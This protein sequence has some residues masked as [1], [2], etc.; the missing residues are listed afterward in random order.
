EVKG[1]E[2]AGVKD[3]LG[4]EGEQAWVRPS[5]ALVK[6]WRLAQ[7][8]RSWLERGALVSSESP[9][10]MSA[11]RKEDTKPA[12]L[13]VD[14]AV[15]LLSL[16]PFALPAG[17][18]PIDGVPSLP[19]PPDLHEGKGCNTGQGGLFAPLGLGLPADPEVKTWGKGPDRG[20]VM[21]MVLHFLLWED[22][23]PVPAAVGLAGAR[24]VGINLGVEEKAKGDPITLSELMDARGAR[25]RARGEGLLLAERLLE[26]LKSVPATTELL[27]AVT[28]NLHHACAGPE[29][30]AERP[31]AVRVGGEQ[32]GLGAGSEVGAR[33]GAGEE[34]TTLVSGQG[35]QPQG[36][37]QADS[38]KGFDVW[39]RSKIH[40]LSGV[41]SCN[42]RIKSELVAAAAQFL[43]RCSKLLQWEASLL[44]AVLDAV[45]LDYGPE[46]HG[47]LLQ[48]R[49][50]PEVIALVDD[51]DL[52]VACVAMG[53][54]DA[55]LRCIS[56][57]ESDR[58]RG[59]DGQAT[60]GSPEDLGSPFQT[61]FLGAVR[62]RLEDVVEEGVSGKTVIHEVGGVGR[63][64][65]AQAGDVEGKETVPALEGG[66]HPP[67]PPAGGRLLLEGLLALSPDSPGMVV[68]HFPL[69]V[70][71]TLSLWL[72][73]PAELG[74]TGLAG[75]AQSNIDSATGD[76]LGEDVE[77]TSHSSG[78][79]LGVRSESGL[80]LRNTPMLSLR[81]VDA[82]GLGKAAT[83]VAPEVERRSHRL[84][85]SGR[86]LSLVRPVE[87]Y[88]SLRTGA[89]EGSRAVGS[90]PFHGPIA[91]DAHSD[92]AGSNTVDALAS[93]V[94]AAMATPS[95]AV[96]QA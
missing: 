28:V 5:S 80:L 39:D 10:A 43:R 56:Q 89:G 37:P 87:G 12:E 78:T 68:P 19:I 83:A 13:V 4:N 58:P 88:A 20:Q 54:M 8:V 18:Q 44:V 16:W 84:V 21:S 25:A 33:T 94:V 67:Q 73:V 93:A 72:F 91:Q 14:R 70:H 62:A 86:Q 48:S 29:A 3:K 66:R 45:S 77:G 92:T 24:M 85:G 22:G 49:L 52:N 42:G 81:D 71:Y 59:G 53:V 64:R 75:R 40:F 26:C 34:A 57:P 7:Q 51:H 65:W 32:R 95:L 31:D 30:M 23:A 90:W 47:L 96:V 82:L 63:R 11:D 1:G 76:R 38:L 27:R 2:G 61:E 79:S 35:P 69:G 60:G 55:F 50:L 36:D 6:A 15:F 17:M 41:Y 74:S 46:D 9:G